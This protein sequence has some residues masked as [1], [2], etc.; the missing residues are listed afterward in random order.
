MAGEAALLRKSPLFAPL[1]EQRLYALA[2][3]ATEKECK[4]RRHLMLDFFP[5]PSS[6]RP[7]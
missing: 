5:A 2:E 7:L 4:A 1:D 6:A 3:A